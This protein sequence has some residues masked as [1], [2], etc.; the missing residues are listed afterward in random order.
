MILMIFID[1][2]WVAI[3]FLIMLGALGGFWSLPMNALLQHRATT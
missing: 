1:N 3:P 2:V